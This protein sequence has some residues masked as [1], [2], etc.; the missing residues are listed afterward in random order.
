L[1]I[2]LL[3]P[4]WSRLLRRLCNLNTLLKH[5]VEMNISAGCFAMEEK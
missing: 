5:P 2:P 1:L 3:S 4:L